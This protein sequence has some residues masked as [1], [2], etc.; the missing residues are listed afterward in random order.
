MKNIVLLSALILL[1]SF[2]V[3]AET[4]RIGLPGTNSGGPATDTL[5]Q[6]NASSYDSGDMTEAFRYEG[7]LWPFD[8][9]ENASGTGASGRFS[10]S[11]HTTA[12]HAVG[13]Y[14]YELDFGIAGEQSGLFLLKGLLAVDDALVGV[15]LDEKRLSFDTAADITAGNDGSLWKTSLD[16][17]L[18]ATD[19]FV[20]SDGVHRPAFLS[21]GR[22]IP[23]RIGG[24]TGILPED[25]DL[26]QA[27]VTPE[28]G[29]L[30]ILGIGLAMLAFL[31]RRRKPSRPAAS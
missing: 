1:I 28:P 17:D 16:T 26:E 24:P 5:L 20:F 11:D 3:G 23:E 13:Y 25:P 2:P 7:S 15:L 12:T 9:W 21:S 31:A 30:T 4:L 14:A 18:P 8:A 10:S 19:D 29:T 27:T 22:G 6:G